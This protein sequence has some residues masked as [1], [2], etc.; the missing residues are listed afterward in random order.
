MG[1]TKFN[2]PTLT[3]C[4]QKNN[5]PKSAKGEPYYMLDDQSVMNL[6]KLIPSLISLAFS[7]Q[8]A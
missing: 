3:L 1:R 6:K 8:W 2:S 7:H 4:V 5:V